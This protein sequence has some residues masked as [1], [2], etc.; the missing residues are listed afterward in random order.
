MAIVVIIR[1]VELH[2]NKVYQ[3]LSNG[4]CR[5]AKRSSQVM[6]FTVT[7]C[8]WS[9]RE[10]DIFPFIYL[11]DNAKV[12]FSVFILNSGFWFPVSGFR[13]PDSGFRIPDSGFR[14]L[15]SGFRIPDSGF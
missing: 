8:G 10:N 13:I 9:L 2:K 7:V 14:I 1:V 15:D 12:N 4:V 5:T 3:S 11:L 6:F